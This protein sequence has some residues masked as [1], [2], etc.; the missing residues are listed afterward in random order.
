[1]QV[2]AEELRI[3][4]RQARPIRE[5]LEHG[6]IVLGVG[7]AGRT[8]GQVSVPRPPCLLQRH[9]NEAMGVVAHEEG[10]E[11]R[12]DGL[13]DEGPLGIL[14]AEAMPEA[15]TRPGKVPGSVA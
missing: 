11:F 5:V 13:P 7:P 1:M 15:A 2:L 8:L 6:P 12:A 3:G 9:G 10:M 14:Q 4:E